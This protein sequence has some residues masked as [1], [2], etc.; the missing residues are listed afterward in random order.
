MKI[1]FYIIILII[2]LVYFSGVTISFKPF[3]I[4]FERL[5]SA[6]GY[7]LIVVG[8]VCMQIQGY[9][10]CEKETKDKEIIF[11]FEKEHLKH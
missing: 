7:L 5:W 8:G 4:K 11:D 2:A 1:L 9:K 6:I 3:S 10:D